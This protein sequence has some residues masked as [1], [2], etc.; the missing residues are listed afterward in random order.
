M[1]DLDA[2]R[3]RWGLALTDGGRPRLPSAVEAVLSGVVPDLIGEVERLRA[4]N[5][6]LTELARCCTEGE[7]GHDGPCGWYCSYC[8]GT[9]DCPHCEGAGPEL[10][11]CETCETTGT[12]PHCNGAGQFV[13]EHH[14][15][16]VVTA[17]VL[18]GVL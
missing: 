2:I 12:C 9:G 5:A 16:P 10:A 7:P 11:G 6:R 4:E 15:V 3:E 8:A 1:A 17:Q 18:G 14:G 13:D